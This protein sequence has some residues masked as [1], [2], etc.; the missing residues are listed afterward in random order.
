MKIPKPEYREELEKRAKFNIF[1]RKAAKEVESWPEW[2]RNLLGS[3]REKQEPSLEEL[4]ITVNHTVRLGRETIRYPAGI[5]NIK[6]KDSKE[7]QK[8][9]EELIKNFQQ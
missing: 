2:K 7:F 5:F 4:E 1:L 8:Q 3:W 9:L 6:V